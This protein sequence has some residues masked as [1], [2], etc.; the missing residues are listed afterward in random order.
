M[1]SFDTIEETT[2]GAGHHE[3]ADGNTTV[4]NPEQAGDSRNKPAKNKQ[5]KPVK[6]NKNKPTRRQVTMILE[7]HQ[8]IQQSTPE[9]RAI[10]A[11]LLG[12]GDNP[13][14]LTIEVTVGA[15]TATSI[16]EQIAG[17][18]AMSEMDTALTLLGAG[19]SE[20]RP[21]WRLTQQL[22]DTDN[23]IPGQDI[24]AAKE[25]AGLLHSLPPSIV[26]ALGIVYE[27]LA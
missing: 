20:M 23:Q 5:P 27:I 12:C 19:R 17:L 2:T 8:R 21:L 22:L 10:L 13:T 3:Q 11:G 6:G 16:L 14:E 15:K 24:T 4:E 26:E 7:T 25:L 1:G 18:V 9:T